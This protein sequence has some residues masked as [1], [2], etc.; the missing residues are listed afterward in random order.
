LSFVL[1]C[2]LSSID[3]IQGLPKLKFEKDLVYHPCRHGKM[4]AASHS[5]VAEVMTSHPGELLQMDNVCPATICSFGGV[6]C[7]FG[8]RQLFSL[9]LGV[10]YGGKD[11][12]FTHARD[13]ILWLQNKFPKNA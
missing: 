12:A 4:V 5:S 2:R 13:L 8:C 11:E 6:V 3:L 9:F 1:L 7:A 10:L